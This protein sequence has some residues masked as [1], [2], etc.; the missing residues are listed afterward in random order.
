M[1]KT[2]M[3]AAAALIACMGV[4]AETLYFNASATVVNTPFKTASVWTNAAGATPASLTANDELVIAFGKNCE[5]RSTSHTAGAPILHVGAVDGASSGTL[6]QYGKGAVTVSGLNV[7][8]HNGP[9]RTRGWSGAPI[10]SWTV[11]VDGS[12]NGAQHLWCAEKKHTGSSDADTYNL[13]WGLSGQLI[14]TASQIVEVKLAQ[15]GCTSDPVNYI[16]QFP[17][18]GDSTG[19]LGKFVVSDCANFVLGHANAA[20]SP[21]AA[22]T[23]AITLNDHAR[24]AVKSGVTPN[25]ARGITIGGTDVRFMAR[26][27]PYGATDCTDYTLNMPICGTYGFSKTGPGR[28][29]IGGAYTAGAITVEE[30]TL[31]ILAS[32][33]MTAGTAITVKSGAVLVSHQSLAALSITQENGA[34]VRRVLDPIPFDGD[35]CTATAMPLPD[36]IFTFTNMAGVV[37][38]ES[39]P[40][41]QHEPFSC[42][43][44]TYAGSRTLVPE[45]F[46]DETEKT[47]GLPKTS[48][49]I[50]SEDGAQSVYLDVRPVVVSVADI[51]YTDGMNI[52]GDETVWSD[53]APAHSGADYLLSHVFR[54]RNTYANVA[55]N[56]DSLTLAPGPAYSSAATTT[57]LRVGDSGAVTVWPPLT[58]TESYSGGRAHFITGKLHIIG[59]YGDADAFTLEAYLT[60]PSRYTGTGDKTCTVQLNTD[61]SGAGTLA[62]TANAK[63][64]LSGVTGDN[65]AYKGRITMTGH[66]ND[67]LSSGMRVRV[68]SAANFGG[69]LDEFKYDAITLTSKA[70]L[71]PTADITLEDN[72]NRGLYVSGAGVE[73]E[74]GRTFSCAW[75]LRLGGTFSKIG[76]GTLRISGT[77]TYGADG[78]GASGTMEVRE[79]TLAILSD[80]AVAGLSLVFSNG[81]TLAVGYGLET[82]MTV[83][84]TVQ[85]A[86]GKVN[87]TVD[88]DSL[89]ASRPTAISLTVATLADGSAD[90]SGMFSLPRRVAKY[91]SFHLAKKSVEIESVSY[92]RYVLKANVTGTAICIR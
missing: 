72:V 84:P 70:F 68:N 53:N 25:A 15:A 52:N 45:M 60:E 31:E 18:S 35:T 62:L 81:T 79:G 63:F 67:T 54:S 33:T 7:A 59:S 69:R 34:T 78:T 28:V 3:M 74:A 92:D 91:G 41:P 57:L 86:D 29:V 71:Y 2:L 23:D 10:Q 83:A 42:K 75:P 64:S 43:V 46:S 89:P 88:A 5:F 16:Q 6:T 37:L 24:F 1:K 40:L 17:F 82:G 44:L 56:G 76:P 48:F 87:L 13:A 27:F 77:T 51:P 80:A 21:G 39:I 4:H 61:L 90:I 11:T 20:G 73:C 32:A 38:S 49:R 58:I 19:W 66:K 12:E 26:T 14:G 36:D 22:R 30:G 47:C 85:D 50:V 9:I 8:W 55:F 65:S